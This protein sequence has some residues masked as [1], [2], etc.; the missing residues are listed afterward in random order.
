MAKQT[1][2]QTGLSIARDNTSFSFSW[3][4]GADYTSQQYRA[5]TSDI[6]TPAWTNIGVKTTAKK[7][8]IN[9]S[10]YYPN[11]KTK[12]TSV[13][14]GVRGQVTGANWS[15]QATKLVE[16]A[17][18]KAP[19]VSATPSDSLGN[20][21]TF[22]WTAENEPNIKRIFTDVE[23]QSIL[24][25]ESTETDGSKLKWKTTTLGWQTGTGSD[26]G[27]KTITENNTVIAS[28]SHT[29]WFRAR[30]RGPA[31]AS[32]W[33][34]RKRVYA[35]PNQPKITSVE[36]TKTASGYRFLTS[37]KSPA[38]AAYP[39]ERNI[40]ES[41]VTIP[42]AGI[43]VPAG[44]S[45]NPELEVV[46]KGNNNSGL[47]IHGSSIPDD[48]VA[49]VRV[50][51]VHLLSDVPSKGAIAQLGNLADPSVTN[52][53]TYDSTHTA[54]ITATNASQVPGAFLVIL[55]RTASNPSKPLTVG[56]IPNGSSSATVQCPDWDGESAFELGVYAAVG[57]YTQKVRA[58]GVGSYEIDAKMTSKGTIWQGGSVPQAPE[59][60]TANLT[61]YDGTIRVAWDWS[62]N[63]AT[64]ATISWSDSEDAWESTKEPTMYNVEN[65]NA[66]QWNV[67]GLE[68]GKKWY[69]RVR[70]EATQGDS[71]VI[72]PWS[73]IVMIDLSSAPETPALTLSNAIITD[74]GSVTAYWSYTSTDGTQQAYAEIC[75]ATISEGVIT[76]GDV[77]AETETAQHITIY[78]EDVGWQVGETHLLCVRV[79]S[80]SGITSENWSDP[81]PVT[82]AEPI[83]ATF[84]QTSLVQETI[85]G[86]TVESLKEMP[87]TATI[88][89]AGAGGTTTLII[90]RAE[91]YH[92]ER[93]DETD[94]YGFEGETIATFTQTGEA[95]IVIDR[96]NLI[97]L[98]DDGARYRLIAVIQDGL[99]QTDEE[100]IEFEVHWTNQALMPEGEAYIEGNVAVIQPIAPAGAQPTDTCDI[101]RLSADKPELIVQ[102]ATFGEVYVDPYPTIGEFGGH[103]LVYIT[104]DGD[105]ITNDNYL[106][107][108]DLG[109]ENGD[110]LD[111]QVSLIDFDGETI[112]LFYDTSQ[113]NKWEKDF[114]ETR[115]L[116][117]SIQGDWNKAVGRSSSFEVSFV[118]L[119]D[120][121]QIK[122]MRRLAAY[123]GL[124]HIRTLDGSSY[125]CDIQ[126][127]ESRDYGNDRLRAQ[128]SL[129]ITRVDS[130][131]LNGQLYSEY[132]EGE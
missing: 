8:T 100:I 12:L 10:N 129:S 65:P 4:L 97:G 42:A 114:K 81:V 67:S 124:C 80:G 131:E 57:S 102:G 66:T 51:A 110:F 104:Q 41:L 61:E 14:F 54:T 130:E 118:T 5:K 6:K 60:V 126:V 50:R 1:K 21:C 103:R 18:P 107:W 64:R 75:E 59:N 92:V 52:I 2:A 98:L 23:W 38:N 101:Y 83:Y 40:L 53:T 27:S 86:R 34:Y 87:L 28:G 115:Y 120:E 82:I 121:S 68:T 128:F 19:V 71:V 44:A 123:T 26:T 63:K 24:V 106:A 46:R 13:S 89:G 122:Q 96:E 78:A 58:D 32:E 25:A 72:G 113:S 47:I 79:V 36:T 94:F 88:T 105:Y 37:W 95:Q 56:V 70:F 9:K 90:E 62:W 29:R 91:D 108:L 30:S 69:V 76:Y 117:G 43:T 20:V 112:E 116:G 73:D 55:Y 125:D 31:G 49:F 132:F 35:A 3:K 93:P 15:E 84:T 85:D 77:I 7:L 39:V 22:S 111:R 109:A 33:R 119:E 127:N 45:W 48:N 17:I 16:I 11:T 74:T 99:G